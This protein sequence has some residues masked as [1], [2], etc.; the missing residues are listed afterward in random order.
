MLTCQIVLLLCTAGV[1]VTPRRKRK[2]RQSSLNLS[3]RRESY[4]WSK[5][6]LTPDPEKVEDKPQNVY[7]RKVLKVQVTKVT[8][9]MTETTTMMERSENGL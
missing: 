1:A 3:K 5:Y 9:I 8:E 6:Y 2:K 7:S 4:K